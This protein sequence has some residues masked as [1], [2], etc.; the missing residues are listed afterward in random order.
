MLDIR[1][2]GRRPGSMRRSRIRVPAPDN[3][4]VELIGVPERATLDIDVRLE[5]VVEGVLVTADVAAPLRGECGRCLEPVADHLDVQFQELFAY[6][7]STTSETTDEE[8]PRLDG[9]LLDL[10]PA[11]RDAVVLALPMTP[12]CQPDCAGLCPTCGERLEP[13]QGPHDH[14]QLDPR[15]A[16]LS[17]FAGAEPTGAFETDA[18]DTD[19]TDTDPPDTDEQP[20]TDEKES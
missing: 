8:M 19:P 5:S 20:S 12:L 4:R 16:G 3:L 1:D 6:D 18:F 13:G 11:L 14:P 17:R 2:L 10:E 15:W 9:D 7:D